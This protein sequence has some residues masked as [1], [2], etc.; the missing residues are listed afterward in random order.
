MSQYLQDGSQVCIAG[1][2]PAGSFAAL[3][4]LHLAQKRNL[5]LRVLI[6][7]PRNFS[8][9][10]PAGCNR[11]AGILSSRLIRSLGELDLSLPG[12]VIQSDL[13][14]YAIHLDGD[15]VRIER[16]DPKRQIVSVYRGGGPRLFQGESLASFDHFLLKQAC[17]RGAEHI[18][19]RIRKITWENQPVLH[20]TQEDYLA[21]LMILATGVN[22]HPLLASEIG[23]LFPQT[24]VMAQDEFLQ[25]QDW[26]KDQVNIYFGSPPGILFGALIPK[27]KYINVSLLG[28]R[29]DKDSIDVFMKAQEL[30]RIFPL[31]SNRLCG[32][33]PRLA[34]HP[35]RRYFG[36]QWVAVGDAAVTRLYKDGIGSAFF[37]SR[38]AM[39]VAMTSGISKQAF[40]NSYAPYCHKIKL[41]NQVGRL[42]FGLWSFTTHS[43]RLIKAWKQTLLREKNAPPEQQIHMRILWGMF[44]G[45]E[46][47]TD[48]LRLFL[49]KESLRSLWTRLENPQKGRSNYR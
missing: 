44:T 26:R 13:N 29:M 9:P 23:Y 38:T 32:C 25:P 43:P 3:H 12:E 45:D 28:N 16:P 6:F 1:G 48:L 20:T 49:S 46:M 21:D 37:T 4:L 40:Q 42:L 14:A 18:P 7:E 5:Q 22:S 35:S 41:D 15:L 10:G 33:T 2:G 30:D 47:Y 27:G 34:V 31:N 19:A 39:Q 8:K 17:A 24:R 36:P 11:C